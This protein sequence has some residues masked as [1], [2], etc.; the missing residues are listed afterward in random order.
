MRMP[1]GSLVMV[2]ASQLP[3]LREPDPDEGIRVTGSQQMQSDIQIGRNPALNG[4]PILQHT[5]CLNPSMGQ[6]GINI[7][8]GN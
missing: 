2:P 1:N 3:R 6:G 8:G 7:L 4:C 5:P